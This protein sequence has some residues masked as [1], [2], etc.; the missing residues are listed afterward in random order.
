MACKVNYYFCQ[1][2][3]INMLPVVKIGK[4]YYLKSKNLEMCFSVI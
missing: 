3:V 4:Y 1:L 2:P